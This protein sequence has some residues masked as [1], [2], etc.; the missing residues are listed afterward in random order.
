VVAESAIRAGCRYYFGYPITPQNEIPEYMSG[1]M[2]EVGGAFIQGESEIASVNM[3]I[4]AAAAGGRTMTSSSS[5]GISLKMEAVSYMA[6]ME[7]P[8]VFVNM[9]RGGPGLG[10]IAPSQADYFQ[11]TRGGGHGDYRLLVLAPDGAQELADLTYQAFD[12]AD[13]YRNPVL[14]LG[15]GLIGQMMEPVVLPEMRDLATLPKKDYILDG[16]LGREKRMIISFYPDPAAGHRHN[17]KL[18]AKYEAMTAQEQ[19][20]QTYR[21]DDADTVIVA[22]GTASRIAKGAINQ[23]REQGHK[24]GLFRP[25]SLWPF[26]KKALRQ[27]A[28]GKAK[29][30]VFEMSAGQLVEDVVLS[31]GERA[32]IFLY[33]VPGGPI[34]TPAQVQAFVQSTVDGDGKIGRR[35]EA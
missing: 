25:I 15:D 30:L 8:V 7:L 14:I 11:A 29:V 5:P 18:M 10:N 34:P 26:P 27:T 20:W 1:R 19:R 16:C 13:Q 6:G 2:P 17:L 33:G 22:Y 23:L 12:L 9:M 28:E 4:G 31:V 35:V 3:V 21:T 24:I 32:P